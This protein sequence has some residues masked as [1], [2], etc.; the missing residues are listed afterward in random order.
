MK[1]N[2]QILRSRSVGPLNTVEYLDLSELGLGLLGRFTCCPKVAS[3][4]LRGNKLQ[5]ASGLEACRQ[6]WYLD[7]SNNQVWCVEGLSRFLCLGTLILSNNQ[8]T[9]ASLTHLRHLHI[10]NLSL[11]GNPQLEKDPYYRIHVIDCLPNVWMLDGRIVT[12]AERIQV[13][14]FFHDSALTERPVRHKLRKESFV[15]SKLKRIEIDGIFGEKAVEM[16][17]SFPK[18]EVLNVDTD[19]RRLQYLAQSLQQDIS[20]EWE[21]TARKPGGVDISQKSSFLTDLFD[22]RST[23]RE[24]CNMVLLMLVASLNFVLP[25]HLVRDTLDTGKLLT[26]GSVQMMDLFLL[27][28]LLRCK[29]VSL[30]VSAV[31]VDREQTEDGGLYIRLYLCLY[32]MVSDLTKLSETTSTSPT[33]P[34]AK[35]AS[36][37]EDYK[38]L[39]AT[40]VVQLMCIVPSFFEYLDKDIG[41]MNLVRIATADPD[42]NEKLLQISKIKGED[43]LLQNAVYKETA[44]FLL[45][46]VQ[47]QLQNLTNKA[48]V[49]SPC[50]RILSKSGA[51]PMKGEHTPVHKA[52]YLVRGVNAPDDEPPVVN[53]RKMSA[54]THTRFPYLGDQMLLGPQTI[55][56]II[57]LPQPTMALVIIDAVPVASGA[58][59]HKLKESDH[60]YTYVNMKQL[61]WDPAHTMWKPRGTVGDKAVS[62]PHIERYTLQAAED[63]NREALTWG[64]A[65]ESFRP[66]TPEIGAAVD[67]EVIRASTPLIYTNTPRHHVCIPTD[68][69]EVKVKTR[70]PQ[71]PLSSVYKERLKL[72]LDLSRRAQSARSRQPFAVTYGSKTP[73]PKSSKGALLQLDLKA[74]PASDRGVTVEVSPSLDS[75]PP[76]LTS[77]DLSERNADTDLGNEE[78][79]RQISILN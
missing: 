34:P 71:R 75:H 73:T 33:K 55:G 76:L 49:M 69:G 44:D 36:Q 39:L 8:L 46:K 38:C 52:E 1:L 9:W 26:I 54:K 20:R 13:R 15:P 74:G 79:A 6:L 37:L 5:D 56:K 47:E 21:Y 45:M 68:R 24:R 48:T 16:M 66:C 12:S 42:I 29:V 61:Q 22:S 19:W 4:I 32:H 31:K 63:F 18:N 40:E 35:L 27:P 78:S 64:M 59:E 77:P 51:L 7:L 17:T 23:D 70:R 25:T 43:D 60:H 58:V 53:P 14:Q 67:L 28:R 65:D 62:R 30:L 50:D 57:S 2:N 11:H 3:L 10:N 72:S 41:V